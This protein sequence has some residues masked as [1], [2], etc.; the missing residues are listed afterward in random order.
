[1]KQEPSLPEVIKYNK[2]ISYSFFMIG[3]CW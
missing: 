3:S 2:G 1:L